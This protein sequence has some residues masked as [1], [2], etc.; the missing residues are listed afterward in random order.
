LRHDGASSFGIDFRRQV[1]QFAL[2][3]LSPDATV[4]RRGSFRLDLSAQ[5]ESTRLVDSLAA[6][7]LR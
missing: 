1:E 7:P 3:I 4:F 2:P 5:R 6:D